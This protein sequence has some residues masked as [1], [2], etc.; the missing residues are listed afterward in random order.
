VHIKLYT[1]LLSIIFLLSG[2]ND[3]STEK[4]PD[5][6][7][8]AYGQKLF[9]S[10]IEE[11]LNYAD[12]PSDSQFV[13][14][15]YVDSWLI[16]KIMYK[17]ATQN[18]KGN[19]SIS[20][21]I[22]AYKHS[23]YIYEYENQLLADHLNTD[24]SRSEIDTFYN[25]YNKDFILEDN[26]SQLLCVK[27]PS[28]MDK[29]TFKTLW[30]TE[31]LP[32]LK[33]YLSNVNTLILLDDKAWYPHT[34]IKGF[35]P[36]GLINKINFKKEDSYSLNQDSVKYFV[37]ILKTI[38]S[39]NNAPVSYVEE[40]IRTRILHERSQQLLK[41]KRQE[42]FQEGIKNKNISINNIDE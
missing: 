5:V 37:K 23:L 8:S 25:K 17:N 2:C 12:T 7:A 18:I 19:K 20:K 32:A 6:L 29:D 3:I 26:I 13:I 22:D 28:S 14:S 42:L 9:K 10:D 34:E 11:Y 33:T 1:A 4:N 30:K 36:S 31:D 24:I 39:N 35:L 15:R 40:D 38:K 41:E 16:D 21:K 27:I